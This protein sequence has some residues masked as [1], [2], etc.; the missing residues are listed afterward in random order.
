MFSITTYERLVTYATQ[1]FGHVR[2]VWI[3]VAGHVLM[4]NLIN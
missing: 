1:V 3:R 2:Q 4:L